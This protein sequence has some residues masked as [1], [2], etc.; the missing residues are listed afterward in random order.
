MQDAMATL[1]VSDPHEGLSPVQVQAG[2]F[3]LPTGSTLTIAQ[4]GLSTGDVELVPGEGEVGKFGRAPTTGPLCALPRLLT[5]AR[6]PQV[7][8]RVGRGDYA[9]PGKLARGI[10]EAL[11]STV[12]P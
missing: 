12:M 5:R 1:G 11:D 7:N 4:R 9:W 3:A 6:A 2:V 8:A 10:E